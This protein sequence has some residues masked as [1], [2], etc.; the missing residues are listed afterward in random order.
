[1]IENNFGQTDTFDTGAD[2]FMLAVALIDR[3]SGQPLND[4]RFVK[5]AAR[6]SEE[7]EG[8]QIVQRLEDLHPCTDDDFMRLAKAEKRSAKSI[9]KLRST[10]GLYCI[11]WSDV[12]V[13]LF[14]DR[15]EN[16]FS[17]FELLALPCS[18]KESVF[19]GESDSVRNDCNFDRFA[20][21]D[22]LQN[23]SL[24]TVYNEQKL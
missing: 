4:Q 12:D 7:S 3:E 23:S 8:T 18:Q 20:A 21:L 17:S 22:Y 11:N 1:M 16:S 6:Y 15:H 9:E 14:G 10:G 24:I 13:G 5:W 2:N 19:G